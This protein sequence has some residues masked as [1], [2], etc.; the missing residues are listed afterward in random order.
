MGSRIKA[1]RAALGLTQQQLAE[2][3]GIKRNTIAKYETGRGDP[4]DAVISLI[5]KTYNVNESWLRDGTGPMFTETARDQQIKDFI[6]SAM[7]GESDNFKRRLLSVLS[8][9]DEKGWE[10]LAQVLQ[11][12][13]SA[14][15]ESETGGDSGNLVADL[16]ANI[17]K[18]G[19]REGDSALQRDKKSHSVAEIRVYDQPAA[20]GLGNYLDEPAYHM[21]QYPSDII[22][23]G[24]DFGIIISGDSMEPK[25]HDG[26]TVFVHAA[27]SIE[28]G[29]IGIFVLN[30]EAYCKKL[31]VDR[32]SQ[33]IRLV[34]LNQKY[35]DI[36]VG[37]SDNL[38]TVGRVLG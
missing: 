20:A 3:L 26:D 31:M 9:L 17:Y 28:P 34:S 12:L 13:V 32:E 14:P 1:L 16:G 23:P 22:P 11:G 30:G 35:A 37:Q 18:G 38:R 19:I 2:S 36:R 10:V 6:D 4:I 24:T 29:Q 8:R 21:E 5:C 27:P 33:Q 15:Q 25:V 7:R